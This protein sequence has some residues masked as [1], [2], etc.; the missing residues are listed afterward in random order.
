VALVEVL[1]PAGT[2]ASTPVYVY[3]RLVDTPGWALLGPPTASFNAAFYTQNDIPAV[4]RVENI[5]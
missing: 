3:A 4:L 2:S 5:P 1:T